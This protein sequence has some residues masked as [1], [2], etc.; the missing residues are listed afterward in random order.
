[1]PRCSRMHASHC[2]L[3][4]VSL[5]LCN[6][7]RTAIKTNA[8][9][10]VT[11]YRTICTKLR[12]RLTHPHVR[13]R[14]ET[15][16]K[17]CDICPSNQATGQIQTGAAIDRNEQIYRAQY[18]PSA[19]KKSNSVTQFLSAV[20]NLLDREHHSNAPPRSTLGIQYKWS[21]PWF[22]PVAWSQWNRTFERTSCAVARYALD[23]RTSTHAG[24]ND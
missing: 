19:S 22:R 16:T 15:N 4:N 3:R 24:M 1:M 21:G 2:S 11:P 13:M 23:T 12:R 14:R 20:T 18:L 8:R 7:L 9:Q 6:D 5:L 17:K 10:H